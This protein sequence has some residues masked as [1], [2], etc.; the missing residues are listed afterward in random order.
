MLGDGARSGAV[1][2]GSPGGD[3]PQSVAD[4]LG[5]RIAVAAGDP[6]RGFDVLHPAVRAPGDLPTVY[7]HRS[8][9]HYR[10][11]LVDRPSGT[12][13]A[14]ELIAPTGEPT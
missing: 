1:G 10:P 5:I 8:G 13:A 6:G 7:L 2:A 9:D 4:A 14:L 3:E 12:R 11:V